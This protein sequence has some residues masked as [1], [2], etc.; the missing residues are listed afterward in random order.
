MR[1]DSFGKGC[2]NCIARTIPISCDHPLGENRTVVL[3]DLILNHCPA[4]DILPET[5]L[6][7]DLYEITKR[8]P[9][10]FQDALNFPNWFIEAFSEIESEILRIRKQ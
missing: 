5:H 9:L 3:G 2:L 1:W 4:L 8:Y 7:F 10:I 6:V